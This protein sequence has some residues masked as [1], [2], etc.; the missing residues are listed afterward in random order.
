VLAWSG[1]TVNLQ[2]NEFKNNHVG[3][4][5]IKKTLTGFFIHTNITGNIF[6]TEGVLLPP[7]FGQIGY[8][9]VE[10]VSIASFNLGNSNQNSTP[11]EFEQLD[12]GVVANHSRLGIYNADFSRIRSSDGVTPDF[13]KGNAVLLKN[14]CSLVQTDCT[15]RNI[16]I[17]L[18]A[19]NSNFDFQYNTIQDTCVAGLLSDGGKFGKAYIKHNSIAAQSVGIH[20]Q[21]MMENVDLEIVDNTI[22]LGNNLVNLIG[23]GIGIYLVK[24]KES[25]PALVQDNTIL[26]YDKAYGVTLQSVTHFKVLD[27]SVTFE[28][29]SQNADN[30]FANGYSVIDV[31]SGLVRNNTLLGHDDLFTFLT[32]E[33]YI[34][35]QSINSVDVDF[36][37]NLVTE[38]EIGVSFEG[39][40]NSGINFFQTSLG[41]H[42]TGVLLGGLTMIGDQKHA[43]N[44]WNG[45]F[46]ASGARH[47]SF[48]VDLIKKSEFIVQSFGVPLTPAYPDGIVP[49]PQTTGIEWFKLASSGSASDCAQK[50]DCGLSTDEPYPDDTI[51][52][53]IASG[54]FD[55]DSPYEETMNWGNRRMLYKKLNDHPEFLEGNDL[56][57]TFFQQQ[58]GTSVAD[59]THLWKDI[60]EY[61]RNPL[62][63]VHQFENN[64]DSVWL[65][66]WELREADEELWDAEPAAIPGLMAQKLNILTTLDTLNIVA[67][68]LSGLIR[69]YRDTIVQQLINQNENINATAICEVNEKTATGIF[70]ETV[71]RDSFILNEVQKELLDSI[72]SQCPNMGGNAVY[73][74]RNLLNLTGTFSMYDDH[75]NCQFPPQPLTSDNNSPVS[76]LAFKLMPNPANHFI[77]IKG[78][79]DWPV[80]DLVLTNQLG[81]V[82]YYL[83]NVSAGKIVVPVNHLPN[84]VFLL[85]MSNAGDVVFSQKVIVS[86]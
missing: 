18:L 58:Q 47:K 35:I 85:R 42:R 41:N 20:V 24:S 73:L 56:M 23:G 37:C 77:F 81:Q 32:L 26:L 40:V 28:G 5:G 17:G 79:E 75:E 11:N 62:S 60:E 80:C 63:E 10:L 76:S 67:D 65:K 30:I 68:T 52:I 14:N 34:G 7:R 2:G 13:E 36:C 84:G 12:N 48:D 15:F 55:V 78:S 27:N 66:L 57:Q 16:T 59:F 53:N 69:I 46:F 22:D 49:N 4:Y 44:L 74:A 9:G 19:F 83:P 86:H 64:M 8:A 38:I 1:S 25:D 71:A 82:V 70:L 29:F 33:N 21:S 54:G 45:P 50:P 39:N 61:Y 43:G 51:S 31:N 72:A 6:K 3:I